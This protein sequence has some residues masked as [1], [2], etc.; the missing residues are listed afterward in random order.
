MALGNNSPLF[1]AGQRPTYAC[2]NST[3]VVIAAGAGAGSTVLAIMHLAATVERYEIERIRI[4]V[5]DGAGG[6]Y[7]I[8]V[9]RITASSG[10]VVEVVA[11]HD[12]DDPTSAAD[13]RRGGT[14][15]VAGSELCSRILTGNDN[16][17]VI[18]SLADF[19][20]GK[21]LVCRGGILEGYAV[22]TINDTALTTGPAVLVNLTWTEK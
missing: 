2:A 20:E 15:T 12:Q 1:T 9:F 11:K 4:S 18:F 13:L 5:A 19:P 14:V 16:A 3:G 17:E 22:Q 8:K 21:P 6:R 7:R 10:G